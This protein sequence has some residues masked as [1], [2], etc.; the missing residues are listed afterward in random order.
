MSQSVVPEASFAPLSRS[1]VVAGLSWAQI[2]IVAIG[3]VPTA[4]RAMSGDPAGAIAQAFLYSLPVAA[5]GAGSWEGRSFVSRI[6]TLGVFMLRKR[7]GQTRAVVDPM[8]D[9][10]VGRINVPGAV[11]ERVKTLSLVGTRFAGGAFLW[12]R[13]AG[14]ATAVL[15][16]TTRG[17]MLADPGTKAARARA[18]DELCRALADL[19][20][21]VRV[22]SHARTFPGSRTELAR[23]GEGEWV[24]EEYDELLDHPTL[25]A[26]LHRDVLVALT[27]SK[28]QVKAEVKQ[29]GGGIAGM[30][31]V[32]AD[33]VGSVLAYLPACGVRTE[34]AS[35][36]SEAQIRGAVRLAFDPKAAS[37]LAEMDGQLPPDA[38]LTGVVDEQL[39]HLVTDS[40]FHR[41]WWIERWPSTVV[42][43]GYLSELLGGGLFPHV[44][45]QV[46]EGVPIHKA[47]LRLRRAESSHSSVAR[48]SE[49]I[50]RATTTDHD[51]EARE[52]VQR[53][54]ELSNGFGDTRY[55]GYV[56]ASAPSLAKLK[57]AESYINTNTGEA[58]LNALR[59]QQ[60]A[61][62]VT[63]A[64]PL[65]I[66][67]RA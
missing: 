20:G 55:A 56:T 16:M 33:R 31:A 24:D 4:V 3:V 43:A 9:R 19:E 6:A 63:S 50:G 41:T 5:L 27:V 39:D 52:L 13:G 37:W 21:V 17:W 66:G 25:G 59:G 48:L 32:L 28:E 26:V 30:S 44:V 2:V 62:F 11:G 51:A 35:W 61:A 1:G 49:K 18:F 67:P 38:I 8:A 10:E 46:W 40:A 23:P 34:G 54:Q 60:Y 45:T 57:E 64:L 58:R 22:V 47:E 14:T 65:G 15:R 12:D 7:L 42:P 36:L 53:R 29:A